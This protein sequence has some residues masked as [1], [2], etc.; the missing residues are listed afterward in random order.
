MDTVLRAIAEP[1]RRQILHLIQ[2]AE[3]SA[4]EIAAHFDVTRPAISQHLKVLADA[5]L[6]SVRN[7]GTRRLYQIRP[8]ALSEVK[9]FLDQFWDI[10]LRQ[11]KHAAENEQRKKEE[12]AKARRHRRGTRN[13]HRRA[14]GNRFLVLHRPGKNDSME[15]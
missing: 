14:A 6:V 8:D 10:H 12:H 3:L 1:R 15:R 4:G 9:D 11:L 7:E 2:N 13:P 5:G